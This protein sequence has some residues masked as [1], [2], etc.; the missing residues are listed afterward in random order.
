MP[1]TAIV[2]EVSWSINDCELSFHARQPID[3]DLWPMT[4]APG[5]LSM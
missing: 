1:L 4:Y 3:L 2:R 5:S